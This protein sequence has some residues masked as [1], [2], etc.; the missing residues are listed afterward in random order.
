VRVSIHNPSGE[1]K[2]N[3]T[4]NAEVIRGE[5]GCAWS[6]KKRLSTTGQEPI[7]RSARRYQRNWPKEDPCE[8]WDLQ[9]HQDRAGNG[10]KKGEKHTAQGM[11]LRDLVDTARTLWTHKLRTALTMFERLK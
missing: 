6:A 8:V 5:E 3:M 1:L 7:G 10:I 4:A 9:R 11:T 2:A